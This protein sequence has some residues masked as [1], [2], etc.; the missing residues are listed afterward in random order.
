MFLCK[1]GEKRKWSKPWQVFIISQDWLVEQGVFKIMCVKFSSF[2][3][4]ESEE[5]VNEN[6]LVFFFNGK[7]CLMGTVWGCWAASWSSVVTWLW[8]CSWNLEEGK[9]YKWLP[10]SLPSLGYKRKDSL[11]DESD[12]GRLSFYS[13]EIVSGESWVKLISLNFN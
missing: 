3:P 10:G 11:R 5:M 13:A 9:V 8:T 7:A 12:C 2:S 1:M 4:F 6:C